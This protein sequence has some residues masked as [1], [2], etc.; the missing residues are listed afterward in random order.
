MKRPKKS[1]RTG[2]RKDI[3]PI[4]SIFAFVCCLVFRI[5]LQYIIGV[6]GISFFC[7]ANELYL[8]TGCVL[9]TTSRDYLMILM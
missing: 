8:L 7:A 4:V 3:Y 1:K 9:R 2:S 5:L 6:K